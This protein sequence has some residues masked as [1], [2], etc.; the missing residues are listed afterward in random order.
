MPYNYNIFNMFNPLQFYIQ[1][2]KYPYETRSSSHVLP[3][4]L[5]SVSLSFVLLHRFLLIFLHIHRILYIARPTFIC[6]CENSKRF[7][8]GL[9]YEFL[10]SVSMDFRNRKY[11]FLAQMYSHCLSDFL[12]ICARNGFVRSS[13]SS[14]SPFD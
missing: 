14:I 12:V 9:Y 3:F 8:I 1:H 11:V 5:L 13:N 6:F 7:P 2:H 10:I 4:K